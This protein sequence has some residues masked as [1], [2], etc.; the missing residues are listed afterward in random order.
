MQNQFIIQSVS[1]LNF[2]AFEITGFELEKHLL[3]INN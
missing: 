3:V 1:F 2:L